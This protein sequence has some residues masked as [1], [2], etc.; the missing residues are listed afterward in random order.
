MTQ[1]AQQLSIP[2]ILPTWISQLPMAAQQPKKHVKFLEN[3]NGKLF[4]NYFTSI[5]LDSPH[6]QV[7]D[8]YKVIKGEEFLFRA[9]IREK[10]TLFLHQLPAITAFIDTGKDLCSTEKLLR[11]IY[12]AHDLTK[13]PICVLLFQNLEWNKV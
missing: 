11:S 12:H 4:L 6:W 2:D 1:V 7:G 9:I 5:R 13:E 8:Y 10:K 3:Y